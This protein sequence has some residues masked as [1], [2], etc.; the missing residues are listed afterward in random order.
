[1]YQYLRISSVPD[2]AP[3]DNLA[4]CFACVK[5]R[6]ECH[7]SH[8]A[9]LIELLIQ[10]L[11]QKIPPSDGRP[12]SHIVL[13]ASIRPKEN[14]NQ[15]G[16]LRQTLRLPTSVTVD[17]PARLHVGQY[18]DSSRHKMAPPILQND[19]SQGH[20]LAPLRCSSPMSPS[21]ILQLPTFSRP[22]IPSGNSVI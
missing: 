22:S 6:S 7:Y 16:L 4:R 19:P 13:W 17:S 8:L 2:H 15:V 1:M 9:D 21:P 12:G 14:Q 18:A 11:T 20:R 3:S 10:S 5:R